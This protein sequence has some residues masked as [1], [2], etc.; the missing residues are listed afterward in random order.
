HSFEGSAPTSNEGGP[1]AQALLRREEITEWVGG[2]WQSDAGAVGS[3]PY[4]ASL[5]TDGESSVPTGHPH[6]GAHPARHRR[7]QDCCA[8]LP[9]R[10]GSIRPAPPPPA[11][12][13]RRS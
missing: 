2:G 4:P 7:R 10:P 1:G 5:G 13:R 8:P 9:Q 3:S 6:L 11:L 12:D